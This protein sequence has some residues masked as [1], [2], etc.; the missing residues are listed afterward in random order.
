MLVWLH[1][2]RRKLWSW[3]AQYGKL[4]I[5][6]G[7]NVLPFIDQASSFTGNDGDLHDDMIDSASGA[8]TWRKNALDSA[9]RFVSKS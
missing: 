8:T 5:V 6:N 2:K 1:V 3:Y 7:L 9:R 4:F